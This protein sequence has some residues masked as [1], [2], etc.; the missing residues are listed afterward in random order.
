VAHFCSN[1]NVHQNFHTPISNQAA[2]ELIT[3][4]QIIIQA[5]VNNHNRD[6][7][8]YIWGSEKYTSNKFYNLSFA[9]IQVPP[10]LYMDMEIQGVK[11]DQNFHLPLIQR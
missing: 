11:E 3:L 1:F 7:W 8:T 2:Q 9:S 10:S 5:Q 6:K 4:N